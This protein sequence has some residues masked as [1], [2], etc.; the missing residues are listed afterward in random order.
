VH[1]YLPNFFRGEVSMNN[2]TTFPPKFDKR[3]FVAYNIGEVLGLKK[4][5]SLI[6]LSI[7]W[8]IIAGLFTRYIILDVE[9][10]NK[11]FYIKTSLM[12][13]F[14]IFGTLWMNNLYGIAD[15]TKSKGEKG[16]FGKYYSNKNFQGVPGITRVDK[17]ID[18]VWDAN[19]G[20]PF[21]GNFSVEWDGYVLIEFD[22]DYNFGTV[23]DDGS[24]LYID[25]KLI[26]DNGGEHG[27][28]L[29]TGSIPL[30][31]GYHKIKVEF[32]DLGGGA[33][34][35]LQ[36]KKPGGIMEVIS[37]DNLAVSTEE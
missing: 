12:L 22:G 18:F 15:I 23:S 28:Q 10:Q 34:M 8:L 21:A 6:P 27:S 3:E 4:L 26:V 31:K 29:K 25:N 1:Y 37:T 5:K 11:Y 20:R 17:Q 24:M 14:F 2:V 36:W 33:V 13:M 7:L 32:I 30:T 9:R 16:L 19:T 35:S